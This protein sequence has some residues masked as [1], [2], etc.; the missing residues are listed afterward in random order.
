MSLNPSVTGPHRLSV[1]A[2]GVAAS[3]LLA[4][5]APMPVG[6]SVAVMPGPNKPFEVFMQDDGLCRGWASHS[7]GVPG[8]DAAA[9]QLLSSTVTG[10]AIGAVAGAMIGGNRGA[11]TGAGVGTVVGASAGANQSMYT[12]VNAQRRYDI[13]YQQCMYAKG[14]SVSAAGYGAYG[15]APPGYMPPPPPGPR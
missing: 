6:P 2:A 14:N 11:G 13:A 9:Q 4:G 10:A 5:C 12:A 15:W 8:H 7:I 1:L 3:L